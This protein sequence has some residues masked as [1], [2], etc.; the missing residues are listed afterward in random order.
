MEYNVKILKFANDR[1]QVRFY[2]VPVQF[3]INSKNYLTD[4][5]ETKKYNQPEFEEE[6]TKENL[7]SIINS[8][9]RTIK[10][11]YNIARSNVWDWFVTFTFDTNRVNSTNYDTVMEEI[12]KYMKGL[13]K[14]YKDM[15]YL[16]IPEL[17]DDK[18]KYHVHGLVSNIPDECF[19]YLRSL[20]GRDVYHLYNY[21]L[22]W[23]YHTRVDDNDKVVRYITKY[24]TKS[25][26]DSTKNKR[27]F[28]Y[29]LNCDKPVEIN[30]QVKDIK[31]LFD[32]IKDNVIY[33]KTVEY[34]DSAVL[35]FEIKDMNDWFSWENLQVDQ[36]KHTARE[37]NDL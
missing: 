35:Y 6:E 3:D 13:R 25:L 10:N 15:K 37:F 21:R 1:Q 19:I 9:N 7:H 22:G 27:R 16:L 33:S 32:R 23:D 26:M 8:R 28:L 5:K 11:L 2:R 36:F 12:S 34:M 31:R 29:S 20:K 4:I 14:K 30:L 17:H 24:I 18:K